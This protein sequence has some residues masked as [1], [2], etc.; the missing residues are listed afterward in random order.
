MANGLP[1]DQD[2]DDR[3]Q[4]G[5]RGHLIFPG[6]QA[7]VGPLQA[8]GGLEQVGGADD[9]LALQIGGDRRYARSRWQGDYGCFTLPGLGAG[10][11]IDDPQSDQGRRYEQA[12][13]AR[14]CD[15]AHTQA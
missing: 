3:G 1:L 6:A 8:D 2:V 9:P 12:E 7:T 4:R 11:P 15:Q 5:L 10:P 14:R 13:R